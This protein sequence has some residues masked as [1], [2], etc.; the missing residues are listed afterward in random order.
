MLL[1]NTG[2]TTVTSIRTKQHSVV[3]YKTVEYFSK[4]LKMNH[5]YFLLCVE[6]K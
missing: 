5:D 1:M 6:L 3:F 2:C 4:A